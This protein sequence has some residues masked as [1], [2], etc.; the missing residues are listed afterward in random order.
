MEWL[1]LKTGEMQLNNPNFWILRK[2]RNYDQHSIIRWVP[3]PYPLTAWPGLPKDEFSKEEAIELFE[4]SELW[5][6]QFGII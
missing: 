3:Q 2:N 4:N 5:R 6:K 1:T